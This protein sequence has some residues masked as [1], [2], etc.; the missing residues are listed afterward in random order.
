MQTPMR[1]LYALLI[2]LLALP[3][4]PIAAVKICVVGSHSKCLGIPYVLNCAAAVNAYTQGACKKTHI[5]SARLATIASNGLSY[6]R[7]RLG[8][9]S[10]RLCHSWP[11]GACPWENL[12]AHCAWSTAGMPS[13]PADMCPQAVASWRDSVGHR[14]PMCNPALK[15]VGC[16]VADYGAAPVRQCATQGAVR[17]RAR[18]ISCIFSSRADAAT[19]AYCTSNPF[20]CA[21]ALTATCS[22]PTLQLPLD[23]YATTDSSALDNYQ[24]TTDGISEVAQP[25]PIPEDQLEIAPPQTAELD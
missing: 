4:R 24:L 12:Y 18:V 19:D 16:A 7:V 25:T 9:S 3:C 15:Y 20:N 2:V 14:A 13:F 5:Y 22:A 11:V 21:G 8:C 1:I 17:T 23:A 6:Y 10:S